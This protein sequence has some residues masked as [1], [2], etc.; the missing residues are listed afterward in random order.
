MLEQPRVEFPPSISRL[1]NRIRDCWD[2]QGA[3]VAS[4]IILFELYSGGLATILVRF[5]TA[6]GQGLCESNDHRAIELDE[7]LS[8]A[9]RRT[10][11]QYSTSSDR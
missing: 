5:E 7:S 11:G 10:F 8:G 4:R 6:A 3:F 1:N 9:P 2:I